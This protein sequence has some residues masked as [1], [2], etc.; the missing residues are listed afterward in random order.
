MADPILSGG[1]TNVQNAFMKKRLQNNPEFAARYFPNVVLHPP[2]GPLYN[3][4][5]PEEEG[6]FSLG[7]A[8]GTVSP[9]SIYETAEPKTPGPFEYMQ[10]EPPT[11]GA[12]FTAENVPYDTPDSVLDIQPTT[13]PDV[14][15]STIPFPCILAK[16]SAIWLLQEFPV[17][18][19]SMF[20][21]SLCPLD[22]SPKEREQKMFI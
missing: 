9:K 11:K 5:L 20:F 12:Q 8:R 19:T 14:Y 16:A 6:F 3:V 2:E 21:M 7:P 22:I 10:P 1:L 18:N 15:A 4:D 17:H 13:R